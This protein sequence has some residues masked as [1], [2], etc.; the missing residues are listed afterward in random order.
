[1]VNYSDAKIYKIINDSMPGLV[2]YGATCNTFARK[3]G[4]HKTKSNMSVAKT[5]F[6]YGNPQMILVEKYPC[7]DKMELNAHLRYYIE[8][9][10]CINKDENIICPCGT[11][12]AN[13]YHLKSHNKTKN[14]IKYLDSL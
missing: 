6:K 14:H 7:T 4:T 5:L 9:N 8:N 13:K 10:E 2:Y 1:M 3:L 12:I 11:E